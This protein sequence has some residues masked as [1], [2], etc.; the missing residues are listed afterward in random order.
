MCY[1]GMEYGLRAY[2]HTARGRFSDTQHP[3][4]DLD[5]GAVLQ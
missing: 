5:S 1:E 4:S 3:S 2:H